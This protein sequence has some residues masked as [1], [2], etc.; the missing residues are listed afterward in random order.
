M[1]RTTVNL[2]RARAQKNKTQRYPKY[3]PL[4]GRYCGADCTLKFGRTPSHCF[5]SR[6]VCQ[7]VALRQYTVHPGSDGL[8]AGFEREFI[9]THEAMTPP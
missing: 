1:R 7:V 6:W 3:L 9:D 2:K 4:D 5:A 8:N